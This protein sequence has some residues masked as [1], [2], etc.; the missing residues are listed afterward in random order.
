MITLGVFYFLNLALLWPGVFG[1]NMPQM[2]PDVNLYMDEPIFQLLQ[3][4][5]LVVGL[6]LAAIGSILLWGA[7]KPE[8]YAKGLILVVMMTEFLFGF[9]DAYSA[10]FSYEVGWMA[11]VTI[12]VHLLIIGWGFMVL[13]ASQ[14]H[15]E[16]S[17][18]LA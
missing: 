12:V 2:Y 1:P 9:W 6:G 18:A 15:A 17:P 8:E 16:G 7:R 14:P 4:A 11:V 5:W 3:D 10:I 13:N